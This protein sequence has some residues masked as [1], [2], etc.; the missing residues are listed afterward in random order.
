MFTGAEEIGR[1]EGLKH[2]GHAFGGQ[3]RENLKLAKQSGLAVF[4]TS[5]AFYGR[6]RDS[7][8]FLN[9]SQELRR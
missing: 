6:D 1:L 8:L 5:R 4:G 9:R 3:D 2:A 7:A